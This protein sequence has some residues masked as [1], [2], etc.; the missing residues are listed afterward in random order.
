[1]ERPNEKIPVQEEASGR[2]AKI[3]GNA[4]YDLPPEDEPRTRGQ[5]WL[6]HIVYWAGVV[7]TGALLWLYIRAK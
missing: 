1:L 3:A 2:L 6:L 7:V 5:K 4:M